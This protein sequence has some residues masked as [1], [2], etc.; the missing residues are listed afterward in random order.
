MNWE[1]IP[2]LSQCRIELLVWTGRGYVLKEKY[3]PSFETSVLHVLIT[4]P[5]SY[6]SFLIYIDLIDQF[7]MSP[8][9][10]NCHKTPIHTVSTLF[11][12]FQTAGTTTPMKGRRSV[13]S[14]SSSKTSRSLRSSTRL[15]IPSTSCSRTGRKRFKRCLMNSGS[16]KRF[17][18]K[19]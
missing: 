7:L 6:G 18:W 13:R 4:Y 3:L 2:Q 5:T 11:Y 1:Q 16:K 9:K 14:C 10:S 12:P 19:K 15:R 8:F 17:V